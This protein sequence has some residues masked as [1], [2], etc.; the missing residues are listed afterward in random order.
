MVLTLGSQEFAAEPDKKVAIPF[1]TEIHSSKEF[2]IN[3]PHLTD[4]Q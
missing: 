4:I 3:F 2:K 1:T